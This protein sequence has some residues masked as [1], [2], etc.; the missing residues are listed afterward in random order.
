MPRPPIPL[1]HLS[2]PPEPERRLRF[3]EIVRR[4]LREHRYS[5]RTQDAYVA[6]IRRYIIYSGRRHPGDLDVQAVRAFLSDLAVRQRV[7]ASTQNQA[8]AALLF[9]YG[10]V[11][12]RPL[13]GI[14]DVAPAKVSRRVPVILSQAEVRLIL[15]RLR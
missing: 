15:N 1:I 13:A 14:G 11:I 12:R 8:S 3:M 6:W 9:L 2:G 10:R 5:P 4:V 7:S